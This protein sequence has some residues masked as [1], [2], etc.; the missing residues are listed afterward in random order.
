MLLFNIV[1]FFCSFNVV[2]KLK[3]VTVEETI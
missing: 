2:L 1:D 3:S